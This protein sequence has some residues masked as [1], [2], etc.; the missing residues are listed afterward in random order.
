M[1][2][3]LTFDRNGEPFVVGKTITVQIQKPEDGIKV[4]L[5]D[6]S[7]IF[8]KEITEELNQ[9]LYAGGGLFSLSNEREFKKQFLS[10]VESIITRRVSEAL[11]DYFVNS[12]NNIMSF[13]FDEI[14]IP[15][16]YGDGEVA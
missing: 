8:S 12:E 14:I 5:P 15:E 7:G 10:V 13:S 4:S 11:N 16:Q 3:V 1:K 2:T 6:I 9:A